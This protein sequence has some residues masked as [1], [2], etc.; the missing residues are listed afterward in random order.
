MK[1]NKKNLFIKYFTIVVFAILLAACGDPSLKTN[2]DK[3]GNYPVLDRTD[4]L[5][6]IDSNKNGVRDDIELY[7]SS[8]N[9]DEQ[10]KKTALQMAFVINS[11]IT[12]DLNNKSEYK[13]SKRYA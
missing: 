9:Y 6:G 3:S 8:Q 2:T 13:K 11:M 10:H 4:T 1:F 5:A 12:V 7:I